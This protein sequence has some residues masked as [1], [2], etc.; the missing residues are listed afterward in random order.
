[1]FSYKLTNFWKILI[2]DTGDTGTICHYNIPF[3]FNDYTL[4]SLGTYTGSH[5]YAL[6]KVDNKWY[7]YN[8]STVSLVRNIELPSRT[9]PKIIV[10]EKA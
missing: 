7:K 1:L 9:I 2:I 8:D 3:E 10:Y 5:Y 4:I 6:C